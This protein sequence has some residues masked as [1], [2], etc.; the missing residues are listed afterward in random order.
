MASGGQEKAAQ[1][2]W[3]WVGLPVCHR[4][5][6]LPSHPTRS[7]PSQTSPGHEY[8]QCPLLVGPVSCPGDIP[9]LGLVGVAQNADS[10]PAQGW[11]NPGC[12]QAKG[13][14]LGWE[15]QIHSV[16][17]KRTERRAM[18]PIVEQKPLLPE[19]G[20]SRT[21]LCRPTASHLCQ[22]RERS[23]QL[24]LKTTD[25]LV[26]RCLPSSKEAKEPLSIWFQQNQKRIC[27][28]KVKTSLDLADPLQICCLFSRECRDC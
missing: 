14:W 20:F 12:P 16:T 19:N 26:V 1:G 11:R 17:W 27:F 18:A 25:K 5:S 9:S 21:A 22:E 23:K 4:T 6:A 8:Y 15:P 13:I 7:T 28:A 2:E 3:V 24:G 10:D